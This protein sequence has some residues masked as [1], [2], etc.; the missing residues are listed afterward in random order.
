[1][2]VIKKIIK[3]TLMDLTIEEMNEIIKQLSKK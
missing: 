2:S 3:E 1:M